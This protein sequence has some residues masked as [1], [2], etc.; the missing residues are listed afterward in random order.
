LREDAGRPLEETMKP[1]VPTVGDYMTASPH[2]IGLD[3]QLSHAHKLMRKHEIRHLPVLQ[4][5][6]LVGIL[7]DRDLHLIET[8]KDVNPDAV[9]VEEAM[10]P[11]PYVVTANALLRDVAKEMAERK[12]GCAVVM[13]DNKTIGVFTTVDALRALVDTL[14]ARVP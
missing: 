9:S 3:Q 10:T 12:Y 5:G 2:S 6:K 4:G 7:S 11:L 8:L 14:E 1:T 13:R